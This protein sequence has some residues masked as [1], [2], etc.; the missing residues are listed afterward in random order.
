MKEQP[1]L[2]MIAGP[3]GSGKSTFI[4]SV[5]KNKTFTIR[6]YINADD[7]QQELTNHKQFNFSA[8]NIDVTFDTFLNFTNNSTLTPKLNLPIVSICKVENNTIFL[9]QK[10]GTSYF[11]ALVADFIRHQMLEYKYS[12]EFE[13]VMSHPDK[14]S[15]LKKAND[16][17]YKIYLYFLCTPSPQINK[18]SVLNRVQQGGHYVPPQTIENRYYKTLALLKAAVE[19]SHSVYLINNTLSEFEVIL[20]KVEGNDEIEAP[21]LPE[22]YIKFYKQKLT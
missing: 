6:N 21:I 14:I 22:W 16:L 17:G 7:I 13:T 3:N 12:F 15:F 11:A 8:Y 19:N 2:R 4:N 1:K 9:L 5:K 18:I 10:E 20:Q